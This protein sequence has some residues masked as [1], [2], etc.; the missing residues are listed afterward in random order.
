MDVVLV[1]DVERLGAQGTVV[2]VK[3][4]FA[5][6]YLLPRG[7]AVAATPQALQTFDAAKR[8][9]AQQAQRLKEQAES[10]KHRL[11][12]R[13]LT[14]KLTLGAEDQPFGSVT[15]HD[16]LEALKRD[17]LEIEKPA[18]QLDHP[19]KTL[20]I[21]DVPIRLHAEVLATLKVWVVKA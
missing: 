7:L 9:R 8:R 10:L 19:I 5:R 16:I 11:E 14:L 4:G 3:P 15:V 1:K 2:R 12:S 18:V 17:G 21:Y 13:S 6:N 20:G